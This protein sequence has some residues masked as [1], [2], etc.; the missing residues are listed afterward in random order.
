MF[1]ITKQRPRW[2][3]ANQQ[4]LYFA[5]FHVF[6]NLSALEHLQQVHQEYL[7]CAAYWQQ[8]HPCY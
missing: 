3:K 8:W 4:E 5:Y 7:Y 1:P 6:Y 2:T